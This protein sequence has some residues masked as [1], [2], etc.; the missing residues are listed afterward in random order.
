MPAICHERDYKTLLVT[1][2]THVRSAERVM[3]ISPL[4]SNWVQCKAFSLIKSK[5]NPL[6]NSLLML[7]EYKTLNLQLQ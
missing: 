1:R 2:Q 4:N 7:V 5:T 3:D 6:T